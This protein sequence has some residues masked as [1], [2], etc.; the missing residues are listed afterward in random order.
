MKTALLICSVSFGLIAC[1]ALAA[2]QPTMVIS[3]V[4][5]VLTPPDVAKATFS[6]R[7]E[8]DSPDAA[9]SALVKTMDAIRS[10]L[11]S[12]PNVELDI[13]TDEM[14]VQS[15]RGEDCGARY[16]EAK[17]ST[18][19]CAVKGYVATLEMIAQV[20]PAEEVG[21]ML[22]LASR[23]GAD[24]TSVAEFD[25]RNPSDAQR[26][27]TALALAD[28]QKKAQ[29]IA[30]GAGVKLGSVVN[31]ADSEAL[32]MDLRPPAS[33]KSP[34]AGPPRLQSRPPVAVALRPEFVATKAQLVVTYSISP[35]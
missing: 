11:G 6:V 23:L 3:G 9:T 33:A 7:G 10:G 24:S 30:D 4:G 14:R 8:G 16:G 12:L 35:K 20:S 34:P 31:V 19:P 18:G 2:E 5:Q 21:T 29:M 26:R 27:A 13:T 25:L 1:P 17:L 15:V 32:T 28:A 22:G